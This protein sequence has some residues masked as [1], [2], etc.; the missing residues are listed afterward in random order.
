M[1]RSEIYDFYDTERG[2]FGLSL[3]LSLSGRGDTHRDTHRDEE[4]GCVCVCVCVCVCGAQQPPVVVKQ[5]ARVRSRTSMSYYEDR[6]RGFCRWV[7]GLS[8]SLSFGRPDGAARPSQRHTSYRKRQA[9]APSAHKSSAN[10]ERRAGFSFPIVKRLTSDRQRATH[11][12]KRPPRPPPIS[13]PPQ[14][15]T[16]APL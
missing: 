5:P 4:A 3:S 14:K 6:R 16:H 11:V 9:A 12:K 15:D 1:A 7:L 13:W 2:G 10:H 8:L